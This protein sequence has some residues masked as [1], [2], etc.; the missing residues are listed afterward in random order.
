MT[1]IK[2]TFKS[3]NSNSQYNQT[4][5]ILIEPI[6]K[7]IT[8]KHCI[9]NHIF[10]NLNVNSINLK[11]NNEILNNNYNLLHYNIISNDTL[12]LNYLIID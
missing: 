1:K 5:N 6:I 3:L 10:S 7:I 4:F 2:I 9:L 11:Y 12:L 8:I